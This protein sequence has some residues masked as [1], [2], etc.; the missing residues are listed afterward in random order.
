M[1]FP[2]LAHRLTGTASAHTKTRTL[3]ATGEGKHRGVCVW[4]ADEDDNFQ[5]ISRRVERNV[6][7][8]AG[9]ICFRLNEQLKMD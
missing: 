4:Q 8:R 7:G 2:V 5:G 1:P 6:K 3:V 9:E